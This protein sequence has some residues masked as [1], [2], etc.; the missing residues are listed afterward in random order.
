[1]KVDIVKE[2]VKNIIFI[3]IC[4]LLSIV[5]LFVFSLF[6]SW[7][8]EKLFRTDEFAFNYDA[9]IKKWIGALI[10]IELHHCIS[11]IG[12]GFICSLIS[13]GKEKLNSLILGIICVPLFFLFENQLY[14][15][16]QVV[17]K[18]FHSFTPFV[19]IISAYSGGIIGMRINKK[20]TLK[21]RRLA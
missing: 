16:N 3:L 8:Y 4:V 6:S 13:I 7:A 20:R 21:I 10:T 14:C 5:L 9:K 19:I 2:V 12:G 15:D 18:I 17:N 11:F 1:M